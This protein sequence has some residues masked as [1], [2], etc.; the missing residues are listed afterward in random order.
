MSE[1]FDRLLCASANG[2]RAPID[3]DDARELVDL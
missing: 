1:M 2:V 3:A